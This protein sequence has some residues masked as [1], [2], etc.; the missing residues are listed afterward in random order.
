MTARS[1]NVCMKRSS[2]LLDDKERRRELGANAAAVMSG[3]NRNASAN[4]VE[5]LKKLLGA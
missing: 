4:T 2:T 5:S 3:A 1:P